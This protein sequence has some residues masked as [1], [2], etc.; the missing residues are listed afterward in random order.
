[1]K[2]LV[3]DKFEQS[4]L[5]GISALGVELDYQPDLKD[6]ALRD[7][8]HSGGTELLVVRSTKVPAAVIEGSALKLIIRAGAGYNTIDV[9]AATANGAYVANCPGKNAAAVAELAFGLMLAVDRRIPD[10]VSEFRAGRWSK[11]GFGKAKGL[12]GRTLGLVGMGMIGKEMV[13]RAKAFDMPVLCFSRWM[14]PEDAAQAGVELASSPEDLAAKS[15]VVS[16]HTS[17]N[18]ATKGLLGASFFEAM[19]P[20]SIFI[21]TS[22]AEVVDQS[23]LEKAM[24]DGKLRAGLDVFEDEP[25]TPEGEYSGSLLNQKAAYCTHH[26][27]ASTDQAQEA[28]ANETVRIVDQFIKTGTPPNAVNSPS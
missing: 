4:G 22:R 21:N 13:K 20:G 23:A 3:A 9:D 1:M 12:S 6:E 5:D 18:P 14:T 17:L 11:K 7:A 10:N 26:I 8:V 16:V 15:Y 19:Q 2:V 24:N 27:G 28:V 25:A